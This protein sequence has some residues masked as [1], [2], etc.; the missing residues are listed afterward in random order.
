[1]RHARLLV[2]VKRRGVWYLHRRADL[3]QAERFAR[4]AKKVLRDRGVQEV[5]LSLETPGP[6]GALVRKAFFNSPAGGARRSPP[7]R[8]PT[9]KSRRAAGLAI[10][11]S[12]IGIASLLGLGS[13]FTFPG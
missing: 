6:G 13:L 11:L 7:P 9:D 2:E 4:D 5:I 8:P 3:G 10:G 12:I 1:M